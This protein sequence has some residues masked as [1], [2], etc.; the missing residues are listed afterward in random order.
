ML[1]LLL[2]LLMMM[3]MM[4]IGYNNS[5]SPM[6]ADDTLLSLIADVMDQNQVLRLTVSVLGS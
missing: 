5:C 2:L 1:L 3:M 4:I 6:R